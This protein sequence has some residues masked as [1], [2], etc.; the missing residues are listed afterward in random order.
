MLALLR[1]SSRLA[2]VQLG[3]ESFAVPLPDITRFVP[4][5]QMRPIRHNPAWMRGVVAMPASAEVMPVIDLAELWHDPRLAGPW[6]HVICT[7]ARGGIWG[8][9]VHHHRATRHP[10][11]SS[12][13]SAGK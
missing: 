7:S 12:Y 2:L 13:S 6:S 11:R 8:W 5:G 3:F 4:V 10:A 1:G 9:L